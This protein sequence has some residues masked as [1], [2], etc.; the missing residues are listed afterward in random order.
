[1]GHHLVTVPHQQRKVLET[2]QE[3]ENPTSEIDSIQADLGA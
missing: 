3:M 2:Q 1:M